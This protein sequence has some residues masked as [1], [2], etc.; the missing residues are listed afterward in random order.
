MEFVK[1]KREKEQQKVTLKGELWLSDAVHLHS[2]ALPHAPP[3][4]QLSDRLL[5]LLK[6][7]RNTESE[8]IHLIL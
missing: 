6:S 8:L 4:L 7:S 3:L 1:T 2:P 5:L